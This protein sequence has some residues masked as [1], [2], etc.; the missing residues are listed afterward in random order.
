MYKR[1]VFNSWNTSSTFYKVA[2]PVSDATN[3]STFVGKFTA[4]DNNDIGIG[5][6]DPTTVFTSPFNLVSNSIF[7]MKVFSTE[8][9]EVTFH[10]EN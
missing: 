7:K 9:I 1:Q 4:G 5:V 2:N 10:L 3:P 8:E 6:I